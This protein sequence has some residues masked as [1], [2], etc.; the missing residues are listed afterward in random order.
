MRVIS[1][2]HTDLKTL[3]DQ[4]RFRDDLDDRLNI[5]EL[6]IPPLR[7]R[8]EDI[9]LLVEHFIGRYASGR[10]MGVA[11]EALAALEAYPTRGTCGSSS[12]MIEQA[13]VLADAGPIDVHHLPAE[14]TGLPA[15]PA[16]VHAPGDM[17]PLEQAMDEFE[18]VYLR[19]ALVEADGVKHLAAEALG[20]S[21][22]SLWQKLQKHGLAGPRG[23]REDPG[24]HDITDW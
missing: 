1:A 14:M 22:K 13:V 11:P 8:R 10:A 3:V 7:T 6:T 2:S 21:R 24:T 15:A 19:R 4:G 17:P 9:P 23:R 12:M 18:R 5:L 16:Q 20:I